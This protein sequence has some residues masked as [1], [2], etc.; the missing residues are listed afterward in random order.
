[1]RYSFDGFLYRLKHLLDFP[2]T[3]TYPLN[4]LLYRFAFDASLL[5]DIADFMFLPTSDQLPVTTA[6]TPARTTLRKS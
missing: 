4:G 1:L 6:T 5:G 2:A 3:V